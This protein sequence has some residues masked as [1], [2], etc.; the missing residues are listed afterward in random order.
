MRTKITG[1]GCHLPPRIETAASLAPRIGRSE[2]WILSRTGVRERRVSDEDVAVM[3]ARAARQAIGDG[4]PPDL[5]LN[6]SGVPRQTLP[7]TS[8]FI[9]DALGYE[10]IPS[11]SV[12]ATCLS[13]VVAFHTASCFL[14][15]GAYR[16]ILI[17]SADQ[18]TRGRNFKEPESAALLGDGAAAV[19]VEATPEGEASELSLF[20][21]TTWPKGA[22]LTEVRGG[23]TRRHP[24]H[25][26]TTDDDNLFT[27][28]GP[29]I[30]R[31]A[32]RKVYKMLD[33]LLAEADLTRDEIA[34]VVP[35]QA[36]GMAV[37]AFHR[38]GGF[39]EDQVVDVVAE[40]GNC[41]AASLPMA[42]ATAHERGRFRRGDRV[43]MMGT[44]AGLSIAGAI[45]RF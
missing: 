24:N 35:H 42:L 16:R 44:G 26:D 40:H 38:F 13:F 28:S 9:Q 43:L 19:V 5:I 23:G 27:M 12:H 29:R 30:Y 20:K 3:G 36:S 31:M 7:D 41:V 2:A 1:I 32:R 6:A 21:M 15:S 34:A 25:P 18:G 11:H 14:L 39:R 45:I 17:V 8:V 33:D 22:D 4:P 37:G 10:G